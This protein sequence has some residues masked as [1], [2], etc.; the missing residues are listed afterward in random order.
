MFMKKMVAHQIDPR[1]DMQTQMGDNLI[2]LALV[3]FPGTF[4]CFG[5]LLCETFS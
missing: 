5:S 3:L 4:V 1:G 2:F